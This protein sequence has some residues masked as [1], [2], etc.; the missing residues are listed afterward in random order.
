MPRDTRKH[1][2]TIYVTLASVLLGLALED[3]VSIVR[4]MEQR[5]AFVWVTSIFVV[6][7]IM[8]AWIA[9]TST[10]IHLNLEPHPWD[11]LNVFGLSA[12]HFVIN[13]FVGSDA[14]PF[15]A[16]VGVYSLIAAATVYSASERGR[17]DPTFNFPPAE[18]RPLIG[19][20][21]GAGMCFLLFA[22]LSSLGNVSRGV[23]FALV[24]SSIPFATVWL[25][26]FWRVWRNGL[27]AADELETVASDP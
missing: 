3:L 10:A 13:S 23:Q 19:L 25:V 20:N 4:G 14:P 6:H 18:F 2:G 11:A 15:L 22:L 12:A 16:A 8:N 9:Y 27:R 17:R 24:T 26:L 1:F 21:I 7:I 5:D